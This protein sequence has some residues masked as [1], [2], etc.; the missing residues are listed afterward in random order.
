MAYTHDTPGES[1]FKFNCIWIDFHIR[2]QVT[3][4]RVKFNRGKVLHAF[5]C[6]V[7]LEC[8]FLDVIAQREKMIQ[9]STLAKNRLNSILHRNHLLLPEKPFAPE[10]R[11][12]WE[13]L[14]LSDTELFLLCSD[15]DTLEFAHK[16]IERLEACL[17]Q[18]SA[19]DERISQLVQLPGVGWLTA[20]TILSAIGEITRFP[21]AKHW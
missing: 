7:V 17:K 1:V 18:A 10:Q 2:L 21:A 20:I 11:I 19:Q 4:S 3:Y 5:E 16:Q 13:S 6:D 14:P 12:W 9:L 15:L 8:L